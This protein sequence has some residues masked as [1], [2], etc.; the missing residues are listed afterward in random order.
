[1]SILQDINSTKQKQCGACKKRSFLHNSVIISQ[2]R[3]QRSHYDY[4]RYEMILMKVWA[5]DIREGIGC[6]PQSI[7]TT[8]WMKPLD[9]TDYEWTKQLD[10]P[11]SPTATTAAAVQHHVTT[12]PPP[13]NKQHFCR[14][15]ATMGEIHL[16]VV[17]R[18]D[19]VSGLASKP[20]SHLPHRLPRSKILAELGIML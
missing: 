9:A 2:V 15:P 17:S 12:A 16:L 13:N 14:R 19:R 10:Q 20:P 5:L 11:D 1:M 8:T 18:V 4:Q 6:A 7:Q 3:R